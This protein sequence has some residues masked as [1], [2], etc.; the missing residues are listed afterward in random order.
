MTLKT[1]VIASEN[2]A[3]KSG[4]NY[5]LKYIKLKKTLYIFHNKCSLDEHS[6]T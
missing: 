5:I 1:G 6:K 4:I 3:L 2:S